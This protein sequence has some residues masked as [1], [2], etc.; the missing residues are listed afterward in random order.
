METLIGHV[1]VDAGLI[2][3]G[4]PCYVTQK[5][6]PA[7]MDWDKFCD[8]LQKEREK[9]DG[10][11]SWSIPYDQG[12][13][14]LGIIVESGIGDGSYPVYATVEECGDFGKRITSVRIDFTEHPFL[15][16]GD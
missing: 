13:E 5:N 4:D 11:M 6:H 16:G 7:S 12:H 3:I 8:L 2:M 9:A 10:P 15:G 14:G 1:G